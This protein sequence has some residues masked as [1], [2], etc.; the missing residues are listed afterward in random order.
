MEFAANMEV[1]DEDPKWQRRL[2]ITARFEVEATAQRTAL[3]DNCQPSATASG[4]ND[5]RDLV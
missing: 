4:K 1:F 3:R 2:K 5:A